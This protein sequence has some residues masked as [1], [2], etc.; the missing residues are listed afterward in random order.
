MIPLVERGGGGGDHSRFQPISRATNSKAREFGDSRQIS[1]ITHTRMAP[2]TKRDPAREAPSS[3]APS[4]RTPHSLTE[5]R[6][7][8]IEGKEGKSHVVAVTGAA[9]F[10]GT[11]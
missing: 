2:P 4:A 6:A 8:G 9:S 7:S 5:V 1:G 11:N 3:P 10:L